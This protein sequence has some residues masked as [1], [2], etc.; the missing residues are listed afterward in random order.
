METHAT[1]LS[2]RKGMIFVNLPVKDLKRSMDFFAAIGFD[3]N[4]MFT[5]DKAA[6]LLLG[7]NL[8]AMLIVEPYFRSF[9]RLPIPDT[10]K[11][12]EVINALSAESPAEV[13]RIVDLALAA[14][15]TVAFPFED[16]PGMHSRNF[17]DPDGHVWEFMHMDLEAAGRV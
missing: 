11:S 2:Q 17:K 7:E 1:P 12:V 16:G 14:G 4:P 15:G 8:F 13:D 9:T 6:C 3:F 5:D 10:S